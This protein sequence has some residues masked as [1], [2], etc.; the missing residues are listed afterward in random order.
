[1]RDDGRCCKWNRLLK[2]PSL[3]LGSNISR[4]RMGIIDSSYETLILDGIYFA[5]VITLP[6]RWV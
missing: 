5:S 4:F 3:Y 6:M 1:M 2:A